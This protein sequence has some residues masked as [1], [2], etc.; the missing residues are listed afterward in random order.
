MW[1]DEKATPG[2]SCYPVLLFLFI[3]TEISL[4][5][6]VEVARFCPDTT[7]GKALELDITKCV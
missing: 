3:P 1:H 7:K 6:S 2:S 4:L 5:G